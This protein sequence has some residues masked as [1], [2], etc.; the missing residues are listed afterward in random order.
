[1]TI[2]EIDFLM[3]CAVVTTGLDGAITDD[4]KSYESSTDQ[5][6]LLSESTQKCTEEVC[7]EEAQNAIAAGSPDFVKRSY[8]AYPCIGESI[9]TRGGNRLYAER[10]R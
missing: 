1:M 6:N 4:A 8:Y 2:S 9:Y 10:S 3:L 7:P 5:T